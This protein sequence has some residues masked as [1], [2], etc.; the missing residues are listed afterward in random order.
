MCGDA[1]PQ[2]YVSQMTAWTIGDGFRGNVNFRMKGTA[3][4]VPEKAAVVEDG[5]ATR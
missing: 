3:A 5:R 1:G 2:G 4:L